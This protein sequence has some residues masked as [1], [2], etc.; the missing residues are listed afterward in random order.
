VT[1]T[2]LIDTVKKNHKDRCPIIVFI[3]IDGNDE[4]LNW[5]KESVK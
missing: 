2:F 3:K 4:F 5:I 1:G